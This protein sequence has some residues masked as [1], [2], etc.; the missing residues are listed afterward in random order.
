MRHTGVPFWEAGEHHDEHDTPLHKADHKLSEL[1]K[2]G[3][4][5]TSLSGLFASWSL[6]HRR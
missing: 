1:I 6:S 3:A 4:W 5:A 2:G